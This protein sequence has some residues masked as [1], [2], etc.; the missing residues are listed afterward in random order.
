MREYE[1]TVVYDLAVAETG[2]PDAGPQ[3]LTS[4]VEGRGGKMLKVDHWGRRRMAY[5]I[6]RAIDGDYVVTRIDFDPSSLS[7]LEAA[8][9]IDEKV[10]RHLAVRADELPPP[11]PPREPRQPIASA[12]A[13]AAAPAVAE[14]APAP[15]EAAP[16]AEPEV[17][18]PAK[19][20]APAEA[21]AEA[22]APAAE[23]EAPAEE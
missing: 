4:L 12:E 3:R 8:L 21:V 20:E 6:G 18:A 19:A 5:P 10:Y 15:A 13:P 22:E 7:S 1:L 9:K 23:A 11:P 17:A 14:E 16:A 2:G